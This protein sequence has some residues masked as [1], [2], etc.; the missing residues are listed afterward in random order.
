MPRSGDAHLR[1]RPS[2]AVHRLE[3]RA[4]LHRRQLDLEEQLALRERRRVPVAVVREP[5]ELL[6]R[7]LA[8]VRPQSRAERD[9][10]GSDIGRM[11][12]GAE[13]VREDRVLAMLAVARMAAVAAVQAEIGRA[14][15]RERVWGEG[16]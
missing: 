16:W 6:D 5:V 8:A 2:L 9:E 11:R 7:E 13:A 10:R 14:S 3:V 15:C 4:R 1:E 12:R